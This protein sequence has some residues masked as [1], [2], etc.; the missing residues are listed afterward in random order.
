MKNFIVITFIIA[1]AITILAITINNFN[2]EQNY[3]QEQV[4]R[5]GCCSRHGGVC[6]CQNSR[7]KCCDGALSPSCGC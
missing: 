7:A 4:E 1:S 5:G 6:G 2:T 3:N